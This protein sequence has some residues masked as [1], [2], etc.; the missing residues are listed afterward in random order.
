MCGMHRTTVSP[1]S[2]STR[3]ST[4]C[5]A[6]C[7]GPMLMSMWSPSR[8]GSIGSGG[9]IVRTFPSSVAERGRRVGRPWASRPVVESA[10]STVRRS[11][12]LFSDL[13]VADGEALPH[14]VRQILERGR[15]RQLFHRVA[16][17]RI[18]GE[19]LTQLLRA[20]EAAAQREVLP[21]RE[22]FPVRLPHEQ[23]PE[24]RVSDELYAEHVEALA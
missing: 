14:L 2:S 9:S 22:P 11:A 13:F 20:A 8:A 17:L 3:R 24:V 6:G 21:Q 4:P 18:G 7:C 23:A 16:R 10:T 5:V 19:R 12:I 1:S 15:D